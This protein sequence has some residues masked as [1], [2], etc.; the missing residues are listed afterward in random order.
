[1]DKYS[2]EIPNTKSSTQHMFTTLL[3]IM[4]ILVFGY[5]AY[6]GQIQRNVRLCTIGAII[7]LLAL[8]A[9]YGKKYVPFLKYVS[10]GIVF[11]MSA[12]LW[13]VMG[14]FLLTILMLFFGLMGIY[15]SGKLFIIFTAENIRYPSFPARIFPWENVTQVLLKD[16]ILT[17]DLKD[18]KL[19]Q[20]NLDKE[21]A[22]AINTQE[23]N[24]V[25][26]Q[27]ANKSIVNSQ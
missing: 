4:N 27:W 6:A 22:A 23:F 9:M 8:V 20:F 26:R 5:L 19:M 14:K 13:A 12:V 15:S 21:V 2:I 24:G 25:M 7:N 18:N 3:L 1:M 17:I 11:M 16:D 10:H